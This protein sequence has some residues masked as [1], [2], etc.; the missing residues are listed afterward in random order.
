MKR[1]L[2][3]LILALYAGSLQ[4]AESVTIRAGRFLDG[5]GGVLEDVIVTV[6]G[7]RIV[8][9]EPGGPAKPDWDLRGLTLMPGGIDTVP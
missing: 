9:V 1:A 2:L 6:Q 4:A 7:S 3:A 5:R 8:S